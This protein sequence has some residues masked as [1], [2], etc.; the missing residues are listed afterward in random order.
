MYANIRRYRMGAG[1]VDDAMHLA[2]MAELAV[3]HTRGCAGSSG[4]AH[5]RGEAMYVSMRQY[6][7]RN[8]AEFSRRVQEGFVPIVRQV[9]GFVAWY[10]VD[11]GGGA[12]FTITLCEDRAGVEASV[13]A[14]ADWVRDNV[15]DLIEGSPAVINGEVRVRA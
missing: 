3:V 9:P 5:A 14:A 1:S 10:L 8:V 11:G 7:G 12:L 13:S 4:S 6:N 15:A 2:D